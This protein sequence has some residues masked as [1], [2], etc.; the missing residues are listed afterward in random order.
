MS[1][2]EYAPEDLL[3]L[4]GI[5]HFYFCR[6]QW[7]LIYIEGQWLENTLTVEGKQLHER[8]D[9]PFFNE[10]RN[11]VVITRSMPVSSYKLGLTGTCDMVEFIPSVEGIALPGRAGLFQPVPVEYKHGKEKSDQC[12]ETQLCAQAICLEE[13]LSVPV[14]TGSF[15]YA[16]IRHR[17]DVAFSPELRTIVEKVAQ[18]MHSYM[19]RGYTPR[20][21]KKKACQSCSLKD[22]CIP[23]LREEMDSVA[24]YIRTHIETCL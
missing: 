19:K 14:P 18:E 17:V 24:R 9:D 15:Y 4:S 11:G 10:T 22:I 12:D 13:M 2:A 7:A 16:K 21:K 1:I 23:N 20:V 8:V 5:Q 3:L 6:R